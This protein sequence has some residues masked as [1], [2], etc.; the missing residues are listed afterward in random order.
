MFLLIY[1]LTADFNRNRSLCFRVLWECRSTVLLR[2]L[3][4]RTL[5]SSLYWTDYAKMVKVRHQE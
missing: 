5:D 1:L 3:V 4:I 2:E